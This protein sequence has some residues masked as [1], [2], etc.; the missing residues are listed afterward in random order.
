MNVI[1]PT[2]KLSE[3]EDNGFQLTDEAMLEG[4]DYYKT[5]S[6]SKNESELS[7]THEFDAWGDPTAEIVEFNSTELKGKKTTW[8]DLKTLIEIM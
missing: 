3:L 5:Y 6:L 7:V 4:E 1:K 8:K 2:F